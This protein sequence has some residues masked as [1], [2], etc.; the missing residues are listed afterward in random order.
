MTNHSC[1]NTPTQVEAPRA[2]AQ[3]MTASLPS[4]RCS[5]TRPARPWP[6]WARVPPGRLTDLDHRGTDH[7]EQVKLASD[8]NYTRFVRSRLSRNT[9]WGTFRSSMDP[10]AFQR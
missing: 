6:I 2:A 1:Q 7:L 4:Y 9:K 10:E 8:P 3:T 5:V